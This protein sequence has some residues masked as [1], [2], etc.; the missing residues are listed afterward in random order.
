MEANFKNRES[1]FPN[2]RKITIIKQS[3]N[4]MI[5]DIVPEEG[6]IRETGTAIKAETM[7]E[8]IT[9]VNKSVKEVEEVKKT[10]TSANTTA[11]EAKRESTES[12]Q[13]SQT[14]LNNSQ[15]ALQKVN[16]L[17]S[18]VV[19]GLGT[20]VTIG[21]QNQQIFNADSKADNSA[22]NNEIVT[23]QE[24][25]NQLNTE[26]TSEKQSRQGADDLLSQRIENLT[27]GLSE[28]ISTNKIK[29]KNWKLTMGSDNCLYVEFEN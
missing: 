29:V 8:I 3:S 1:Q 2:R 25:Y 26:L 27:Q 20:I 6:E 22:L 12:K 24:N 18:Q 4:E 9:N 28:S 7:N 10:A 5:A 16:A 21:G 13:Q 14:A 11:T 15:T 19:Q 23:R 17:E